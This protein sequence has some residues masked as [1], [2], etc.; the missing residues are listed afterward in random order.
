M[1]HAK[2]PKTGATRR[3]QGIGAAP[4]TTYG[5]SAHADDDP[6]LKSI[7]AADAAVDF[8]GRGYAFN[9]ARHARLRLRVAPRRDGLDPEPYLADVIDRMAKGHPINRV[10]EL[11]P[12]NWNRQIWWHDRHR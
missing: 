2:S 9:R 12:W 11:L 10:S 8:T 4:G 3:C 7:V 5:V 6:S 1:G